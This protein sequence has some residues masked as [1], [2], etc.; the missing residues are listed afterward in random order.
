MPKGTHNGGNHGAKQRDDWR[1]SNGRKKNGGKKVVAKTG[2]KNR[3][4]EFSKADRAQ[5][6]L[7]ARKQRDAREAERK[8]AE[9]FGGFRSRW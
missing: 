6:D 9:R 1:S 5:A 2:H 4:A 8:E 3:Y 7:E